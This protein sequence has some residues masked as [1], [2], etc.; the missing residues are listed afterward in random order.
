MP[1]LGDKFFL[2]SG[3]TSPQKEHYGFFAGVKR[4]YH[5]I[6]KVFPAFTPVRKRLVFPYREYGVEKKHP[7]LCPRHKVSVIWDIGTQILALLFEYVDERR[8]NANAGFDRKAHAVRF[9][10]VMVRVLSE[11]HGA[12]ITER[13]GLQGVEDIVHIRIYGVSTVFFRK[14]AAEL[15]VP[16]ATEI[17][18][19]YLIPIVAYMY[20]GDIISPRRPIGQG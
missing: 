14:E 17:R 9:S 10:R 13:S 15:R 18:F 16:V 4:P 7:L 3:G 6:G 11:Y 8:R 5:G 2:R 1:A 12:G 19:E 20:H